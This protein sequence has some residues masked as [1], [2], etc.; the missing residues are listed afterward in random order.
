[1]TTYFNF[2]LQQFSPSPKINLRPFRTS[3]ILLSHLK[4]FMNVS[5]NITITVKGDRY[6]SGN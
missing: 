1:M 6:L 5:Q 4:W 2:G 3:E